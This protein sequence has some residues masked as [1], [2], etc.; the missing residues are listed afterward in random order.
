MCDE[1]ESVSI[2]VNSKPVHSSG[3]HGAVSREMSVMRNAHMSGKLGVCSE[4]VSRDETSWGA[5]EHACR[6][7]EARRCGL[8]SDRGSEERPEVGRKVQGDWTGSAECVCDRRGQL[9]FMEQG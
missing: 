6:G 5:C 7:D 4:K 3:H 1:E 8:G 9:E 2:A